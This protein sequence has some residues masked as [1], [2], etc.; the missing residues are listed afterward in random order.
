MCCSLAACSPTRQNAVNVLDI[1]MSATLEIFRE[2]GQTGRV[3]FLAQDDRL[4][5]DLG[6]LD[7]MLAVTAPCQRLSRRVER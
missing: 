7:R 6:I 5:R 1:I 3:V 2:K 4:A